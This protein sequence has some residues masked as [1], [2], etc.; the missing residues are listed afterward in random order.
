MAAT[1][2]LRESI[3]AAK[4]L[5]EQLD[6]TLNAFPLLNSDGVFVWLPHTNEA[7]EKVFV[8]L[9]IAVRCPCFVPC[10]YS[11]SLK[12]QPEVV[13]RN[14]TTFEERQVFEGIS[15]SPKYLRKGR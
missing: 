15:K 2:S 4:I 6:T 9:W 12:F 1:Y 14:L 7:V 3:Q 10:D 11:K 5:S 13:L 8:R